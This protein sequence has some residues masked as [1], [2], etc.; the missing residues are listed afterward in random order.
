MNPYIDTS[1]PSPLTIS[2]CLKKLSG[3]GNIPDLAVSQVQC[4]PFSRP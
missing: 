1:H 3:I 4:S 2:N